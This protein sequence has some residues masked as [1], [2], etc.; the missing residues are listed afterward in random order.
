MV[1]GNA[2][3]LRRV[4][5]KFSLETGSVESGLVLLPLL[6]LFLA[7]LQLISTVNLRNV[8]LATGQNQASRQAVHQVVAPGDEMLELNSGDLFSKLRLLIVHTERDFPS[9]FPGINL[10][11]SGKSLKTTGVSVFEESEECTGGYLLC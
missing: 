8:D 4:T 2:L 6:A 5:R 10:L 7:T 11:M 3:K 9:I 1:L